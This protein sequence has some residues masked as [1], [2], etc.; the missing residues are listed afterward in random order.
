MPVRVLRNLLGRFWGGNG[1]V[2]DSSEDER[3]IP[4][5]DDGGVD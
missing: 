3:E 1:V 2:E 4:P 5:V